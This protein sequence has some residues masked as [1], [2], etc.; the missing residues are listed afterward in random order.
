MDYISVSNKPIFWLLCSLTVLVALG[1][2][3]LY[4]REAKKAAK[5]C[6][7]DEELTKTALKTGMITAIGPA[8]SIFIVMV[9]LVASIGGPMA[10]MRLSIIGSA[11]TEM[12]AASLGASAAGTTLGGEGFTLSVLAVSWFV[13]ALNGAGWLVFTGVASPV[14]DKIQKKIC[15]EDTNWTSVMSIACTVGV[16][17]YLSVNTVVKS[18]GG[19][20]IGHIITIVTSMVG[21]IVLNRAVVPKHPK[22]GQWTLGIV[23]IFGIACAIIYSSVA[24]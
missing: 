8:C 5:M 13:M 18:G 10:W 20:N 17:A 14:M 16:V 11:A 2:A 6:E 7:M 15:G 19:F 21:M 12:S 24:A 9:G 23:M 3:I 4:I 1:Q 22:L